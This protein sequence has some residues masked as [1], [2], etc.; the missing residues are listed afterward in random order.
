[1]TWN[2]QKQKTQLYAKIKKLCKVGNLL[3]AKRMEREKKA[4][5]KERWKV[6]RGQRKRDGEKN[7]KREIEIESKN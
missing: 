5:G 3:V 2:L 4:R 1:M 7:G 6:R